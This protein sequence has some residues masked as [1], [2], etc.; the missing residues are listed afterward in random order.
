[1]ARSEKTSVMV[2]AAL[3][4]AI[5]CVCTMFLKVPTAAGYVHLGTM[6]VFLG[7]YVLGWK[8][9][10]LAGAV[11]T[12]L[13]DLLS[14]YAIWAPGS[15]GVML[16][17]TFIYGAFV[18]GVEKKYGVVTSSPKM[19]EAIG[20][21]CA[22]LIFTLGYFM[23]GGGVVY[24][25]WAAAMLVVVPNLIQVLVG[26]LLARIVGMALCKMGAGRFFKYRFVKE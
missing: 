14:G 2:M 4:M 8:Y 1:M 23:Y 13:A 21:I 18:N 10:T 7:I 15:L 17:A 20:V 12:A 26:I 22:S 24:D 16:A 25:S 19:G 9:G 3:F 11:G 5:T 6:V